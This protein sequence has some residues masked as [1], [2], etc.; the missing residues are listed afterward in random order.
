MSVICL[1]PTPL[2]AVRAARRLCDA[3]NGILFGARVTTLDALVP[4]LLAAAGD[5]RPVLSPLAERLLALEAGEAA[6]GPFA[7]LAPESGLA[8]ALASALGELRRGEV[9]PS[10]VRKAAAE[11]DGR[12]D[13][14]VRQQ[15]SGDRLSILAAAL[16]AYE[17]RLGALGA[18]DRPAALRAAADALARG[19][20]SEEV[21]DLDLLVLDGFHALPTAAFD[22]VAALAHRARRVHA[23]VPFFPERPD[24]SVPAE[25]LLRRLEGLHELAARREVTVALEHLDAGGERAPRLARVLRAV[26]GGPGGGPDDSSAGL[27]PQGAPGEGRAA[28]SIGLVLGAVGAGEE[29]DAEVGAR[30][31]AGLLEMRRL[32]GVYRPAI[33][34]PILAR[35]GPSVLLDCGAN[36]DARPEHVGERQADDGG[37]RE[38]LYGRDTGGDAQQVEQEFREDGSK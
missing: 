21:R 1:V 11:L 26:A 31:A 38:Q 33:A 17:V 28:A 5:R 3:E 10:E 24:V 29:G 2:R 7:A 25:Q 34:V 35:D 18:L 22:L 19:A 30:L 15:R 9:G 14:G 32:P 12:G 37:D 6:G 20:L 16:E 4:G 23:R 8:R 27:A 36:A 13:G